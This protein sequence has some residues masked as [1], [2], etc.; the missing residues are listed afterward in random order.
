MKRKQL[1]KVHSSISHQ[2]IPKLLGSFTHWQPINN[3]TYFNHLN[4]P[5]ILFYAW[6]K[7]L[8]IYPEYHQDNF[9]PSQTKLIKWLFMTSPLCLDVKKQVKWTWMWQKKFRLPIDH[10]TRSHVTKKC[11]SEIPKR[12]KGITIK[13]N[14][15]LILSRDN[16]T[17]F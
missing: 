16:V 6:S 7:F 17:I 2:N 14:K 8:C 10:M 12:H 4:S 13:H 15:G 1:L 5:S 11:V 3:K 9:F